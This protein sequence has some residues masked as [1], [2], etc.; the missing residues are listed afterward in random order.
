MADLELTPEPT[1]LKRFRDVSFFRKPLKEPP[2]TQISDESNSNS[3]SRWQPKVTVYRLLVISTTIALG[4]AKA[5][6]VLYG[7]SYVSTTIEW[8]AGVVV[9]TALSSLVLLILHT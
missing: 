6:A 8:I 5:V 9:S 2:S 1:R 3:N 7:K 4:S